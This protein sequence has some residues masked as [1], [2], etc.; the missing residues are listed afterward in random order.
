[1][2]TRLSPLQEGSA[3]GAPPVL[4][5]LLEHPHPTHVPLGLCPPVLGGPFLQGPSP[6]PR[7]GGVS[8]HGPSPGSAGFQLPEG[9]TGTMSPKSSSPRS[10]AGPGDRRGLGDVMDEPPPGA[11]TKPQLPGGGPWG[12]GHTGHRASSCAPGEPGAGALSPLSPHGHPALGEPAHPPRHPRAHPERPRHHP[13][14]PPQQVTRARC[15]PDVTHT[16]G[17][18]CI[19]RGL[20]RVACVVGVPPGAC[21]R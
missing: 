12:G 3:P 14:P 18:L 13:P 10:W 8:G 7:G 17:G 16:A 1:M 9:D 5:M 2:G 20:F 11:G 19:P 6:G 15:G 4:R 21:H